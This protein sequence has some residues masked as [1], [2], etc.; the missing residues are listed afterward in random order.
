MS[1]DDGVEGM[2]CMEAVLVFGKVEASCPRKC[3]NDDDDEGE[4]DKMRQSRLAP[5]PTN[6]VA[7]APHI[8]FDCLYKIPEPR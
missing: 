6:Y 7:R 5:T 1:F 3:S 4:N 8:T 2:S